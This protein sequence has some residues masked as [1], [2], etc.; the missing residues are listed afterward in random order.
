M[1]YLL[2]LNMV[3]NHLPV[4]AIQPPSDKGP[5][6]KMQ[7]L[8]ALGQQLI[9][10]GKPFDYVIIDTLSE[11]NEWSEW[12]GTYK[13]MNSVQGKSFNRVKIKMEILSR[14]VKC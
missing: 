4:K 8:K 10:D 2:I 6:G 14:M 3:Q 12:S 5:V 7:W 1:L 9:D 11:V 13:Y